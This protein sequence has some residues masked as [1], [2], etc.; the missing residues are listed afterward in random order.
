MV[1]KRYIRS[2]ALLNYASSTT[3]EPFHKACPAMP[4]STAGTTA[5]GGAGPTVEA[6]RRTHVS[7]CTTQ[8]DVAVA[9]A[10]PV[11]AS[12]SPHVAGEPEAVAS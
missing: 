11:W 7:R 3:V 10:C 8:A 2:E 5:R 1:I 6:T 12:K 4:T 9:N